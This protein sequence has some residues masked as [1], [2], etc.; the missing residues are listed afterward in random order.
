MVNCFIPIKP[1]RCCRKSTTCLVALQSRDLDIVWY[2]FHAWSR[3]LEYQ[4]A[5]ATPPTLLLQD[6]SILFICPFMDPFKSIWCVPLTFACSLV[7]SYWTVPP[8][9]LSDQYHRFILRKVTHVKKY[10]LSDVGCYGYML[11][12]HEYHIIEIKSKSYSILIHSCHA[13]RKASYCILHIYDSWHSRTPSSNN[14]FTSGRFAVKMLLVWRRWR[15]QQSSWRD[16]FFEWEIHLLRGEYG[17]ILV[18]ILE[19]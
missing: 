4:G 13:I 8:T 9:N 7:I 2:A 17:R 15:D 1:C 19:M 12:I 10:L 3:H 6:E 16:P 18:L 11:K 14:S 5:A